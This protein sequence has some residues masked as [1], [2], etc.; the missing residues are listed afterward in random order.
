MSDT[1][2]ETR[3]RT[4][5]RPGR[6]VGTGLLG[7]VAA[8]AATATG[9][10]LARAAGVG[11]EVPDD[12]ESIPVSGVAF[13]TGV[14]SLVGVGLAL[15]LLRW[16]T[17]PADRFVR[18]AVGLTAASLVPPFVV[19]ASPGTSLALVVLHLLAAAVMIPTL[20]RGLRPGSAPT[21]GGPA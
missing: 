17:R 5:Q 9:A 20:A 15:A 18:T 6:L 7:T 11:F 13:V 21:A 8:M 2:I 1:A 14:F 3:S 10:A 4:R 12:G 19:G 16:S